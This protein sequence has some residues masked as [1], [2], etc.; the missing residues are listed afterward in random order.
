MGSSLGP[1]LANFFLEHMETKISDSNC[2][3]RRKL[4]ERFVDDCFAVFNIDS[5]SLD[6]LNL[7]NSQ[8]N[9]TKFAIESALQC[10]LFSDVCIKV[11]NDNIDTWI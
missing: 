9:N 8:L 10:I 11:D 5:S 2:V 7:V 3:C 1:T 6:F 4:Y